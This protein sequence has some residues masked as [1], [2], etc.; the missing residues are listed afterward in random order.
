MKKP[1][2]QSELINR[3]RAL[4]AARSRLSETKED[5]WAMAFGLG[6]NAR[7]EMERYVIPMLRTRINTL[8]KKRKGW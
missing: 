8:A 3:V 5:V 1:V 4:Q 7:E 6:A 2:N